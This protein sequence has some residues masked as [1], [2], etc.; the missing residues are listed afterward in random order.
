VPTGDTVEPRFDH[1]APLLPNG[2]VL[3][4]AG[5]A[6]NGLI[7]PTAELFDLGTGKFAS[8]GKLQSPGGSG[9]TATLLRSGEALFAG[10]A[11]TS[12]CNVSCFLT[13]AELY[14]PSSGTFTPVG[15]MTARLA[16]ANATL[17]QNGDV[18]I[19][20][21]NDLSGDNSV[22]TAELY[23]PQPELFLLPV[24]CIRRARPRVLR[25]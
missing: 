1:T 6:R 12:W 24:T 23:H 2:K 25:G 7:E 15:S 16:G 17:L 3:I 9:V 13:T 22:A 21:G 11:S 8:A 19:V 10:G 14:H 5:I 4:A 18:L 20:G